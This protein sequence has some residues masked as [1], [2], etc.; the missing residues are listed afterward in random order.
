MNRVP[1][2][3]Y[4][5]KNPPL[6]IKRSANGQRYVKGAQPWASRQEGDWVETEARDGL[7]RL[8]PNQWDNQEEQ[9]EKF[10]E[11]LMRHNSKAMPSELSES[12]YE[13]F[14]F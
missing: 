12:D 3:I 9:N 6:V 10:R 1:S 5:V 11:D 14:D 13:F 7:V 8:L 2:D 4:R